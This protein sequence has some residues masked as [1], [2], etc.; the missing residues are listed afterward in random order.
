MPSRDSSPRR[1]MRVIGTAGHVDH[2]KSTLVKA[3]TG[4]DPDRL[5]EEK[6]REM[7]I[8]LGFAWFT[9]GGGQTVGVVDVPGHRDFIEN[10]LAGV[11]GIDAILFV[12]AAD[13]G[14][15][16]QTRE[17]LA[18]IDLLGIEHGLIALTKVD[19]ID[20]PE[21]LSLIAEEVRAGLQHSTLATAPMIPVSALNG[22]GMDMLHRT[23]EQV[24][25]G[26]AVEQ[27]YTTPH[28][29]I[30]RVFTM[31]GFGSIVTGT[32]HGGLL[33]VGDEIELQPS[34]IRGRVR[35]IQS[36]KQGLQ[37]ALPGSRAAVNIAGIDHQDIQR[38]MVLSHPGIIVPTRLFDA[39]FRHLA[40]A[41]RP[42]EH[43][44][45]IKV[46]TGTSEATGHVRLLDHETLP[47]G[48]DGWIQIRTEQPLAML[49]GARFIVRYPSPG[50]TIGGGV[51][52]DPHPP[53][54]WKR[55][56]ADV[57]D[58]LR[59]RADG[60]PEQ[61]LAQAADAPEPLKRAAL[62]ARTGLDRTTFESALTAA[63]DQELVVLL[64]DQTLIA[65]GRWRY[66]RESLIEI[67]SAFHHEFPLKAGIPR[68]ELRSRLGI[69]QA[70]FNALIA[71]LDGIREAATLVSATSHIIQFN[72]TQQTLVDSLLDQ[73]NA[74][75]FTPPS[76]QEGM[77]AV[78]SDIY[79]ALLALGEIVQ[80]AP[81]VM[82]TAAAY[83]A[84]IDGVQQLLDLHGSVTA[85]QVR[86][87]FGT[88][89]KYAIGLLEHLDSIGMTRREGDA[90]VRSVRGGSSS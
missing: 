84:L 11:G 73:M 53:Q 8:D 61:R 60:T 72:A 65:A 76:V 31:P 51:I 43:N 63:L 10:M 35:G 86:D 16:P 18:I 17:H 22:D 27:S 9:L 85:A 40:D 77:A 29:P 66:W 39:H 49:P 68:E 26:I 88:S 83:H 70:V 21:W 55:F 54:R 36:Y 6:A 67:V 20:D 37:T 34:G 12:I 13:E 69:R 4:I 81:D 38:G 32:L 48:A 14:I 59:L 42:L 90:R 46:F 62:H 2:G 33:K 24:L 44:A 79:F 47:P 82:F 15:M 80:V 89:R 19:M 87:Q 7:T 25:S 28:L 74:S 45:E 50:E 30:D 5:A 23:I 52:I 57:T 41:S 1:V 64:P 71:E 56:Q 58:R 75:P 3:L 78:G